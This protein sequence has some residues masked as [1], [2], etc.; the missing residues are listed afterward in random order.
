[1]AVGL[2]VG[3]LT[4]GQ[5]LLLETSGVAGGALAL[6]TVAPTR[7]LALTSAKADSGAPLSSTAASGAMGIARTAGT[8][9]A[10]VGEA[11][12]ASA[13]TDKVMWEFDLPE[14]YTAGAAISIAVNCQI[15][16]SGTI[17]AASCTMALAAY[18]ETNGAEAALT[19]TGGTQ[20]IVAA[21][22]TLSWSVAGTGLVPGSHVALELTMLITSSAGANT[23]QVNAVSFVA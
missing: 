2:Q 6:T 15:T 3:N 12:S 17:T 13:K 16:G 10:L 23:G 4:A 11:T 5:T 18:S 20:Q 8:S 22:G 7:Y 1:M 21:G 19:V 9:L 14:T